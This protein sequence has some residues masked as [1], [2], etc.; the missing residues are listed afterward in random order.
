MPE[1]LSLLGLA[2]EWHD[3][4]FR[5]NTQD[6]VW[7]RD[8]G[9]KGW[10]VVTHDS[11][12]LHNQGERQAFIDHRVACFLLSGGQADRWSKVRILAAAWEKIERILTTQQPPYVWRVFAKGRV[13]QLY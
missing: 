13:R 4:H 8:I 5:P 9:Q 6:D 7:L 1:A 12:F 11:H 3:R 10:I 2:V